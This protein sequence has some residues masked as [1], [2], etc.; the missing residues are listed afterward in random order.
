VALS[1]LR[2]LWVLDSYPPVFIDEP[3][4]CL[5]AFRVMD[6]KSFEYVVHPGAPW[7]GTAW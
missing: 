7:A 1:A 4:F 6:G 3:F 2:A 5:S